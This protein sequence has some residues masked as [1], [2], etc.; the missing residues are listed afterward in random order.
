MD[1]NEPKKRPGR[2]RKNTPPTGDNIKIYDIVGDNGK[3]YKKVYK[4]KNG[5]RGRKETDRTKINKILDI[6]SDDELNNVYT[7]LLERYDN[8]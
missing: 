4:P 8:N 2:P 6:L 7:L 3:V 1:I 5:K